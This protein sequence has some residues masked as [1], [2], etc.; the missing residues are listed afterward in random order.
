MTGQINPKQLKS[1]LNRLEEMNKNIAGKMDDQK[2]LGTVIDAIS[3]LNTK[4]K[5][6][7]ATH[8]VLGDKRLIYDTYFVN[9]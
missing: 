6:I 5:S 8:L 2:D 9:N 3:I 4:D 1:M 7:P